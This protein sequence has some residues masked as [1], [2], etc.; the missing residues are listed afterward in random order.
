M[1]LI[2]HFVTQV[3][4]VLTVDNDSGKIV[5]NK[6]DNKI[7]RINFKLDGTIPGRLYFAMLNPI[8][9][10]YFLLP[11]VENAITITTQISAYPGVWNTL[12]LGIQDDYEIV[13]ENIDQGKV[14]Y[15]SNEFKRI[16]VRD[17]FLSENYEDVEAVENPEID[18][19]ID[20]MVATLQLAK[21]IVGDLDE[22]KVAILKQMSEI[23]RI[24]GDGDKYLADDGDYDN[25]ITE[26]ELDAM[27][28]EV[29]GDVAKQCFAKSLNNT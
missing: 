7:S 16:V 2:D 21:T 17:N 8:T 29:F 23:L 11:L 1:I 3:G 4:K 25:L 26:D 19:L 15:V 20:D 24:D 18:R 5:I 22:E 9:N 28:E 10:K 12:L 13:D 6:Y 27:L 14:T